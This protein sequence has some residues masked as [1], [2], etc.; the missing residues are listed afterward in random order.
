VRC[1][2]RGEAQSRL[3]GYLP[4]GQTGAARASSPE[5]GFP[6]YTD[7]DLA[8]PARCPWDPS[9]LAGGSSGGAAVAVAAGLLPSAHGSDSGGTISGDRPAGRLRVGRF[10][11]SVVPDADLQPE[12]VAALDGAARLLE[13]LGHDV[14]DVPPGLLGPDVLAAFEGVWALS[15]T[16]LPVPA[17]RVVELRPLTREF[18]A[19]AL[20]L[21]AETT[22]AALT[23]LR[24]FARRFVV[25]TAGYDVLL[26][27]VTTMTP[28]PIGWFDAEGD[29][30]LDFERQKRYAAF[31]ALFNGPGSPPRACRRTG[32]T[33]ACRSGRCWW[34][35]PPTTRRCSRCRPRSRRPGRGW[36]DTRPSGTRMSHPGR[37]TGSLS[38]CCPSPRPC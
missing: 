26:A 4:S 23:E 27:P 24:L 30:A 6:C 2:P 38:P 35:G 11:E 15:A 1:Q 18:R 37:P 33:T 17:E 12:V 21:S 25:A 19:R 7:N 22:M 31:P 9:L 34:D 28:R 5:F 20:A 13:R 36:T 14:E 3:L 16:L 10:T 29:G 32:R 8:G